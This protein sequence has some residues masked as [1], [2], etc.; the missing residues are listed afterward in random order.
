MF[1]IREHLVH[2]WTKYEL[3]LSGQH[4]L[5]EGSLSVFTVDL[6]QN[7]KT[8][9]YSRIHPKLPSVLVDSM[10]ETIFGSLLKFQISILVSK[11][12]LII[13]IRPNFLQGQL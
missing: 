11:D 7:L 12:V 1:S 10:L 2:T 8:S 6:D 3:I 5:Q 4:I 13:Y 9:S